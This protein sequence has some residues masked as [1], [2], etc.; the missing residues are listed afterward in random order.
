[1]TKATHSFLE[2]AFAH[3]SPPPTSVI[4]IGPKDLSQPEY[5]ELCVQLTEE[6][7]LDWVRSRLETSHV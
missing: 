4:P 5:D 2:R 3:A 6:S 1:M 7:A